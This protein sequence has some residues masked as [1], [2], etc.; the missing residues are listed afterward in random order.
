MR[1]YPL[2]LE[3]LIKE[4]IW[5]E[6]SWLA[7]GLEGDLSLVTNGFLEENNINELVEVYLGDFV[8]DD[9]YQ[10]Y[11]E[12][13]PLLI[14]SLTINSP[15]SLQIHPDDKTAIE[16]HNSYGKRECWYILEAPPTAKIYLGLNRELTPEQ[17]YNS[18]QTGEIVNFMNVITPQKGD[19]IEILPGTIHSATGGL[20]ILEVQQ[21]SDVTYRL[22]DWEREKG[23]ESKRECHLDL[24]IDCIDYRKLSPEGLEVGRGGCSTPYFKLREREIRGVVREESTHFKSFILYYIVEGE[25]LVTGGSIA[26]RV[27]KG[28]SILIPAYTGEYILEG[29]AKVLEITGV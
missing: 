4:K 8:G 1:L 25:L 12:E 16:R 28:E 23:G 21:P 10:K 5:G 3:P 11:G 9:L 17:L 19:L 7:S 13:F 2:K 22:Y 15:I 29:G 6:E 24:A 27:V 26:E 20:K 18:C 14:K